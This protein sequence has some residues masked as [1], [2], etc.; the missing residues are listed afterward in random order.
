LSALEELKNA[1]KITGRAA[2][3]LNRQHK[4]LAEG[5]TDEN[6]QTKSDE[7]CLGL[8]RAPGNISKLSVNIPRKS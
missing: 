7:T 4:N 5:K 3:N 1:E 6:L 2:E 8:D